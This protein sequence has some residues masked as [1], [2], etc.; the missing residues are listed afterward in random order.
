MKAK[1]LIAAVGV[2]LTLL[3]TLTLTACG[4][5][6]DTTAAETTSDGKTAYTMT[7]LDYK[8]E[9]L[10]EDLLV[11]LFKDGASMGMMR[12]DSEGRMTVR[13]DSAAYTF[14]LSTA[15]G[16]LHYDDAVCV[17]TP[18]MPSVSVTV[19]YTAGEPHVIYPFFEDL[20]ER[21]AYSAVTVG[22]G[23]TYV[24]IDRPEMSYYVFTPT[25][26]GVYRFT[27]LSESALTIGY[28]GDANV[29]L[30]A[31]TV[32]VKERAFEL[33]IRDSSIGTEGGTFS[34]VIGLRSLAVKNCILVIERIADAVTEQ[35][36]ENL[37]AEGVPESFD[38]VDYLNNA[39]V[40]ISV[41]DA[42]VK[43]VYSEVD[44]YYHY[45][46][47]NGPTVYFRVSS[48]SPYLASFTTICDTSRLC[49]AFYD[50]NGA[51]HKESYN[52][53][54][55]AYAEIADSFGI[56][57]LNDELIYVVKSAGDYMGWWDFTAKGNNIFTSDASGENNG[58][59]ADSI[60][61]E[62]AWMFACCYIEAFAKG[63]HEEP[64]VIATNAD[65]VYELYTAKDEAIHF[66]ASTPALLK[67]EEAE[68][69]TVTYNG[70]IYAAE[71]GVI[72]L[73]MD[74]DSYRF[75]ITSS[76]EDNHLL[77][78]TFIDYIPES[79]A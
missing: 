42:S 56:V 65:E 6:T 63:S 18:E 55:L 54:I 28:F 60:V 33:E 21:A 36:W 16:S 40:D 25:R 31:S 17:L 14:T 26:G 34:M 71:N 10:K 8:G 5:D 52:E 24:E 27:Y 72:E 78:L 2:L 19:Y 20:N 77:S 66:I 41:L 22:E 69:I 3:L 70:S 67:I 53:I 13:L 12:T 29:V 59:T 73:V 76:K 9:A 49:N 35:Q 68:G 39:L 44:G 37:I 74:Q 50:E 57:P 1:L 48:A 23:A 79:D 11:E 75:S 62:N 32:E 47:A 38:K 64:I 30:T 46:E 45:G 61:L 4:D 43:L 7:V 51:L 58:V 15:N